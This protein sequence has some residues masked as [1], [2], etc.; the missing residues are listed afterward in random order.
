MLLFFCRAICSFS[1]LV[2]YWIFDDFHYPI[3]SSL[4]LCTSIGLH[5]HLHLCSTPPP[6]L[7]TDYS[8]VIH[9]FLWILLLFSIMQLRT[10][11]TGSRRN[12]TS[13]TISTC[14][15]WQRS[16]SMRFGCQTGQQNSTYIEGLYHPAFILF[17]CVDAFQMSS[18][19]Y[20]IINMEI[21]F[22]WNES[23]AL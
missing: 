12:N 14:I 18:M 1:S 2:I 7:P 19:L 10:T 6:Q 17:C 3:S 16:Q 9:T 20:S 23:N 15:W 4:S 11:S 13:P 5:L 8:T 21:D 22:Q